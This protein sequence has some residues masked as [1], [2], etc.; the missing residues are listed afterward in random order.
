MNGTF[1]IRC[2]AQFLFAWITLIGGI[3]DAGD[4]S[5]ARLKPFFGEFCFR[6]HAGET[7]E[8]GLNLE[9][10][11]TDLKNP[12]HVAKWIRIF[13]R[14]SNGEMPP[15]QKHRP[16]PET[17]QSF[18]DQLGE[19]LTLADGSRRHPRIRRLNRVEYEN[20][21]RDLFGI[22]VDLKDSLPADPKSQGFD[23]IGD[24]LSISTEQLEV[25]LQATEK[26]LQQV[27]GSEREP[28]RVDVRM[29]LS[30][31][32]FV[33]RNIGRYFLKTDDDSLVT[34]WDQYCPC[35]FI[36]GQAKVAGTYRMKL[37]AKTSV[38]WLVVTWK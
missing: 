29:P 11:E 30:Q 15:E 34:F 12:D 4:E 26:I 1:R 17:S 22:R 10:L 8:G 14:V 2:L 21:V 18:L 6:C 7:Y 9:N 28:P 19:I 5:F 38:P 33:S 27:F 25:Y 23:N 20:T 13:D 24:V 37:Q 31:D 32:E 3:A 36:A 35:V 16:K